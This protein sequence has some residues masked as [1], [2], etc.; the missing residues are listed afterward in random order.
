MF[1]IRYVPA[2]EDDLRALRRYD[3]RRIMDDIDDQ[4]TREPITP[5]RRR[6]RLEGLAPPWTAVR[7]VWQLRIGDFRVFYD[8]D[9][10]RNRVIIRAVRHKGARMTED[11]L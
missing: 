7:P 10:D 6:K 5:S 11:I 2:V 9:E 8:V 3:V 4:L 1:V